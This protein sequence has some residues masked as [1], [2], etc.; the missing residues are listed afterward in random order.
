MTISLESVQRF[1]AALDAEDYEGVRATL[2]AHCRYHAPEGL[3]IG[4]EEIV[5]SYRQNGASGRDR[6]EKIEYQSRVEAIGSADAL[7][8]FIDRVML[9]GAWH[10]FRCR[11]QIR[12]G[13]GGLVEQI[14]HEE[15]PGERERLQQFEAGAGGRNAGA[16]S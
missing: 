13:A 7:I 12:I 5:D 15:I 9:R 14:W 2:A 16:P 11:Q 1:A 10:D 8:T 3:R 6:F 4:P